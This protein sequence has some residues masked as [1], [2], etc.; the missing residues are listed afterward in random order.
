MEDNKQTIKN[1]GQA[2]GKVRKPRGQGGD[3]CVSPATNPWRRVFNRT[4]KCYE[5]YVR[6]SNV[7][8]A[9]GIGNTGD[10]FLIGALPVI[11]DTYTKLIKEI[12]NGEVK[13]ETLRGAKYILDKY[14]DNLRKGESM[15]RGGV[16][17]LDSAEFDLGGQGGGSYSE[18]GIFD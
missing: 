3:I 11:M 14:K 9:T 16:L 17:R 15:D 1:E 18:V 10:S 5:V 13:E 4:I 7:L 8:V 2:E 12:E 6:G